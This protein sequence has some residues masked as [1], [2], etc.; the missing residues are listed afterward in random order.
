MKL[1]RERAALCALNRVFGYE[2][3]VTHRLIGALGS[4]SA[5]F[6]LD[7]RS[8]EELLG[9]YSKHLP[10]LEER[11]VE[12]A[13]QELETLA[14]QGCRFLCV[15]D[16][17]YPALLKECEDAPAGLYI[18]SISDDDT[19]FGQRPAVAVVGTRDLS[20]YGREWCRRIVEAMAR[21]KKPPTVVSGFALGTDIVAHST[22]L[23]CGLPTIAVLPTGI[24][25]VYPRRHVRW[26][27]RLAQ[28]E[29]CALVTDYPPGTGA[30]AV[31]FLRRNRIIAGLS[32][33][34]LLIESKRRG[35]GLITADFAFNYN[36]DVFALPGRVDDVR[37]E[38]CNA[39]IRSRIA[40]AITDTET[41]M[42]DL[43]LGLAT[44]RSKAYVRDEIHALYDGVMDPGEV[45]FIIAV[46]EC[47]KKNRGIPPDQI[48][49]R[50]GCDY[51][52]VAT[53]TGLLEADGIIETDL[54]Q[55]CGIK[56]K[57]G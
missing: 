49:A 51:G 8:K 44:R 19:L 18:R 48:A 9:P 40:E 2:P 31:N 34:T 1:D 35:G 26:A 30:I 54:L 3:N 22:A 27:E 23:E 50:M 13:A 38:G 55:G 47:I 32:G 7:R 12:Q 4:A 57:I 20:L 14:K 33:A 28:T 45:D 15:T 24:D 6:D 42:E 36:R 52:R 21:T 56:T 39:L 25:D 16:E 17:G 29:G 37:S 11:A 46:A 41:L 43:G 5:L 10:E 53:A